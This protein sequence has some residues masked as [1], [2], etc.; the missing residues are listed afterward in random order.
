MIEVRIEVAGVEAE[1][2][3]EMANG[4]QEKEKEKREEE[5][6][7]GA[8]REGDLVSR[9]GVQKSKGSLTI[10]RMHASSVMS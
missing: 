1:G 3:S 7:E 2:E 10:G 5:G 9:R 4:Q 6:E 8:Q